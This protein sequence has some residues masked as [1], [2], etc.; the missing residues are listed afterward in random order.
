MAAD[1]KKYVA[2]TEAETKIQIDD[3]K[4]RAKQRRDDEEC[5]HQQNMESITYGACERLTEDAKPQDMDQDWVTNFFDKCRIVSDER[6]QQIWSNVLAGESNA[7][8][9]FSR[10][11][12]NIVAN[13]DKQTAVAFENVCRTA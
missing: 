11:T 10:H 5:I 8:G 13:L 6:M 4:R 12:V 1:A 3:M 2:I 9:S 7:T